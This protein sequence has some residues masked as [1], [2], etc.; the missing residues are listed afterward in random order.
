MKTAE[1]S[2]PCTS[3]LTVS[4]RLWDLCC[5]FIPLLQP[6]TAPARSLHHTRGL[7]GGRL[8]QTAHKCRKMYSM[9]LRI[10]ENKLRP[11]C[12]TISHCHTGENSKLH[13]CSVGEME[14]PG[15]PSRLVRV[16]A[17]PTEGSSPWSSQHPSRAIYSENTSPAIWGATRGRLFIEELLGVVKN[18][19]HP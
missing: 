11:C 7:Q 2:Q 17:Q 12:G 19:K 18:W 10:R 9:S 3:S 16:P 1:G 4:V 6:I 5:S 8:L 13:H 14:G 15:M